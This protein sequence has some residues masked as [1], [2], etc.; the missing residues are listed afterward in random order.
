RRRPGNRQLRTGVPTPRQPAFRYARRVHV[1]AGAPPWFCRGTQQLNDSRPIIQG[2]KRPVLIALIAVGIAAASVAAYTA[3]L[4]LA[5]KG[6]AA[7]TELTN[8]I[9]VSSL[10]LRSPGG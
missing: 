4:L 10:T 9:D 5:P 7:G 8:P 3:G 1:P 2:V 6:E